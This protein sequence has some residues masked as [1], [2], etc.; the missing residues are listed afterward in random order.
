M[1]RGC[2]AAA[3]HR[4]VALVRSH[5]A[6]LLAQLHAPFGRH[7]P[8]SIE[9]FAQ[10]LLPFRRQRFVLL[11]TLPKNLTLLGRHGAPLGETL[12]R[13]GALLRGH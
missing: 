5:L 2:G 10:L 8:E 12:L 7:L 3:L 6:P 1:R 9:R 13:T 4:V 11:P